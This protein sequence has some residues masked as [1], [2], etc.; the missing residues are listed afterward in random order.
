MH[1][2]CSIFRNC[3]VITPEAQHIHSIPPFHCPLHCPTHCLER[4]FAYT[5]V[6][7]YSTL[8][9]PCTLATEKKTSSSPF[10]VHSPLKP[11]I[12]FAFFSPHSSS[13][14]S[15]TL[16]TWN[17]VTLLYLY[18]SP[19]FTPVSCPVCSFVFSHLH[20]NLQPLEVFGVLQG[21]DHSFEQLL[22]QP[23]EHRNR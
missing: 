1:R 22:N 12:G 5:D 15:L 19:V 14:S 20:L 7:R 13:S 10:H 8:Y 2:I 17:L 23:S 6:H 21:S 11:Q 9:K 3:S 18:S 16:F 4:C